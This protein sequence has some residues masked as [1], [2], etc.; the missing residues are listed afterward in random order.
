MQVVPAGFNVEATFTPR[1]SILDDANCYRWP[2]YCAGAVKG[3]VFSYRAGEVL[4]YQYLPVGDYAM[5]V[6]ITNDNAPDNK[7]QQTLQLRLGVALKQVSIALTD[8]TNATM[9]LR[10][11]ATQRYD[12]RSCD[13]GRSGASLHSTGNTRIV[14]LVADGAGTT[15]A[16]AGSSAQEMY[17][18]MQ[19]QM[20]A[21]A[22]A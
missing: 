4:Y 7:H 10:G 2:S 17:T 20:V 13:G 6:V 22:K 8:H 18:Y 11:Q 19:L 3:G 9:S 12:D 1:T 14:C 15:W 16:M 5:H 21:T